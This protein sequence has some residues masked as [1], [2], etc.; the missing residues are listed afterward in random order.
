MLYGRQRLQVWTGYLRSQERHGKANRTGAGDSMELWQRFTGRARTAILLA[1]D[2]AQQMYAHLI[3]TEHMLLGL[4]RLGDCKATNVLGALGVDME[5]LG[6]DLR[7]NADM[8]SDPKRASEITFT[9]ESERVLRR[10]YE[11]A[12]ELRDPHIGTEQILLSLAREDSGEVFRALSR[13][14]VD[15][16]RVREMIMQMAGGPVGAEEPEELS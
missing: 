14:G 6:D 16:E 3:G 12:R 4:I 10:A 13:H 2:E 9:R 15:A 1:H 8:D 7:R 5:D 11:Q